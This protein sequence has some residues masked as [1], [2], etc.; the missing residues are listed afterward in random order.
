M[1][2]DLVAIKH[3]LDAELFVGRLCR[4]DK[5]DIVLAGM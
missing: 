3:L 4:G 5:G 1:Q 2:Q